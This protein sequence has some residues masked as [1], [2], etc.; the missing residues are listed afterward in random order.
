[1]H[2]FACNCD[3][4]DPRI[5]QIGLRVDYH[6]SAPKSLPESQN[7]VLLSYSWKDH[8]PRSRDLKLVSNFNAG[9]NAAARKDDILQISKHLPAEYL[10]EYPYGTNRSVIWNATAHAEFVVSPPGAGMDCHRH[11]ENLPLE[12]YL[13]SCG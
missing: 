9:T 7:A 12:L 4:K 11:W 2:A 8:H 1:V 10:Q 5:A 6:S 13:S 3:V